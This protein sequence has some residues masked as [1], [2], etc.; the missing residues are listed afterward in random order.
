MCQ[1]NGDV[2]LTIT[3]LGYTFTGKPLKPRF[4]LCYH[5]KFVMDGYFSDVTSVTELEKAL[6]LSKSGKCAIL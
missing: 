1:S 3:A 4:P 6:G 5:E 2:E